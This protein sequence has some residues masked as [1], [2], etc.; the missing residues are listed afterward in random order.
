MTVRTEGGGAAQEYRL[1]DVAGAAV[2]LLA[3]ALVKIETGRAADDSGPMTLTLLADDGTGVG[4]AAL[5]LRDGRFVR[6][7]W[8]GGDFAADLFAALLRARQVRGE[9]R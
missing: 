9:G 8:K 5:A 2:D 3:A 7:T 4:S 1:D 6:A